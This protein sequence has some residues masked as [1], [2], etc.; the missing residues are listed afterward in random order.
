MRVRVGC[1]NQGRRESSGFVSRSYFPLFKQSW[2]KC[3]VSVFGTGERPSQGGFPDGRQTKYPR[4][5]YF[6]ILSAGLYFMFVY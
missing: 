3:G 2:G 1:L 5:A 6:T 4:S